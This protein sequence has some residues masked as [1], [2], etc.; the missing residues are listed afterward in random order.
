MTVDLEADLGAV[1]ERGDEVGVLPPALGEALLGRRVAVGVLQ[2]LD[3]AEQHRAHPQPLDEAVEVADHARLVAVDVGE[4]DPGLVGLVLEE[5]PERAVELGV[6]QQHVLAVLERGEHRGDRVLDGAGDVEEHV[7]VRARRHQH[8]VLGHRR[9]AGLD[10]A[11]EGGRCRPSRASRSPPPRRRRLPST[12]SARRSRRCGSTPGRGPGLQ[13]PPE[14]MAPARSCLPGSAARPRR[15][16]WRSRFDD[17]H[18]S[19]FTGIT[20]PRRPPAAA[21]LRRTSGPVSARWSP[22]RSASWTMV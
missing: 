20:R 11:G 8:R 18:G 5:R 17:D 9:A 7:D 19:S 22:S 12:A 2:A 6:H 4:D 13:H 1:G 10:G 16:A 3:V 21:E 15:R 14:A